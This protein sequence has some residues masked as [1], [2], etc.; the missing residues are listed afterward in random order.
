MA[1]DTSF[2]P[3]HMQ[4]VTTR[5]TGQ[6]IYKKI[7]AHA[8]AG[9]YGKKARRTTLLSSTNCSAV[10]TRTDIRRSP[11][12]DSQTFTITGRAGRYESRSGGMNAG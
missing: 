1:M 12:S 6:G 5:T 4:S 8:S 7:M 10:T 2:H 9:L 11:T 3:V